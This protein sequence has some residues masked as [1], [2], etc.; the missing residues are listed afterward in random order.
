V[1]QAEAAVAFAREFER[2]VR[3][4]QAGELAQAEAV[5]HRLLAITPGQAYALYMLGMVRSSQHRLPEAAALIE[6]AIA[7]NPGEKLFVHHLPEI[8][9]RLGRLDE[10]LATG[11]R[12]VEAFPGDPM[13]WVNLAAIHRDRLE[14]DEAAARAEH[15]GSLDPNLAEAHFALAEILLLGG[16]FDRGWLEY[17]WRFA[18]AGAGKLM[19]PIDRPVW[20]GEALDGTLL[21]I[22]DQ[23]VGDVIQFA[24]FIPLLA[25]RAGALAIACT[26]EL[27]PLL[28]Q[29]WPALQFF[30]RWDGGIACDAFVP[31][32]SLPRLCG[33]PPEPSPYLRA[34]PERA[35]AWRRRLAD[36]L[37]GDE[38]RVGIVWAGSPEHANDFN[39]STDF[40]SFAELAV[41]PG[42]RLVSLQRGPAQAQLAGSS[43]LDLGPSL[44]D[45]SDTMGL[46]AALDL[47]VTVD[48]AVA[49]LAGAMGRP[50][51]IL[52]PY[53][54]DWRWGLGRADTDWYS[55]TRLFR[56]PAPGDWHSL[57]A[58][59]VSALQP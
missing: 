16:D 32:S 54:P 41:L 45:L 50:V 1:S 37:P 56:Q 26:A 6:Q 52:L 39:R 13:L 38:R 36:L 58:Q 12:S 49:H 40:A 18:I 22:A 23:G 19:E 25:D 15:A 8:Y 3:H 59:V 29:I 57:M 28:Q 48:T 24:R 10:A 2:A 14:L 55:S 51:W 35:E 44:A 34:D 4:Q 53:A 43:V 27:R 46:L 42:V 17:E 21:L 5:I 33:R 47:V 9:R 31:L 30:D 11:R 7:A 20:D